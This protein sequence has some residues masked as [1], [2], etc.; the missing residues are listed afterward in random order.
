M[1]VSRTHTSESN[2]KA[3]TNKSSPSNI[4]S[5]VLGRF[6][7]KK[8]YIILLLSDDIFFKLPFVV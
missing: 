1:S 2:Q 5:I 7:H 6:S 4:T 8:Y 3:L